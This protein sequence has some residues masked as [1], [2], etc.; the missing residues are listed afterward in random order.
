MLVSIG[1]HGNLN[2]YKATR[3]ISLR[4]VSGLGFE[5]LNRFAGKKKS[6]S[7]IFVLS[8]SCFQHYFH[9]FLGPSLILHQDLGCIIHYDINRSFMLVYCIKESKLLTFGNMQNKISPFDS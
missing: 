7:L 9:F 6:L 5:T 4:P 8:E 3:L 2:L 1:C